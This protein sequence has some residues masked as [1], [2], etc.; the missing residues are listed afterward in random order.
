MRQENADLV[1]RH[2]A[3]LLPEAYRGVYAGTAITSDEIGQ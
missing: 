2:L 3:G 1:M